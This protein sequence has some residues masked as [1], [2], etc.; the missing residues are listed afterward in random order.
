[1]YKCTLLPAQT[2][3]IPGKGVLEPGYDADLVLFDPVS[4]TH[5]GAAPMAP[6]IHRQRHHSPLLLLPALA[7]AR[8]W[9]RAQPAGSGGP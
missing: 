3:H 8:R 4:Y 2:Y 6:A 5:L 9:R 1:M 7:A